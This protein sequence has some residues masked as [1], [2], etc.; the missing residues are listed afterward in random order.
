MVKLLIKTKGL[1]INIPG[2][3]PFRTPAEVDISKVNV[4]IAISEL[5]KNGIEK[6]KIIYGEDIPFKEYN[7]IKL[8]KDYKE[9]INNNSDL[10]NSIN[11]QQK[12]ISKIEHLL[13]KFL[14]SNIFSNN[15]I[16]KKENNNEFTKSNKK[17]D[18]TVE[19][20]IPEININNIKIKGTSSTKKIVNKTDLSN[21]SNLK[22]LTN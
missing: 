2:I 10:I 9:N 21:I 20:F 17:F 13:E 19:D 5:K 7:K 1:F 3:M 15:T 18:D 8:K 11:N 22:K 12:S 14:N 16:V 6:Y 4:N